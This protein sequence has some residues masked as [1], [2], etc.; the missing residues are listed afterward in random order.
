MHLCYVVPGLCLFRY[1][2]SIANVSNT[3]MDHITGAPGITARQ[4]SVQCYA[5]F[6]V[7]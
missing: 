5:T 3:P 7:V 1:L 6:Q 2:Q 4:Y